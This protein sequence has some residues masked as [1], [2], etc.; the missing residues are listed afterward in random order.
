LYAIQFGPVCLPQ[1]FGFGG[2]FKLVPTRSFTFI[3]IRLF[4]PQGDQL[5]ALL[6][7]M[8]EGVFSMT[9]CNVV[10]IRAVGVNPL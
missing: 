1:Q 7:T 8:F 4:H 5:V 6:K 10:F 2:S 9:L 3:E